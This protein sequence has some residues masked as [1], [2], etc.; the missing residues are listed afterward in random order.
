M[1]GGTQFGAAQNPL[2]SFPLYCQGPLHS[3]AGV[4]TS[5][6]FKWASVGAG[7]ANP[8]MGE[9]VWAD[10]GPRGSEIEAGDSNSICDYSGNVINLA[11][12]EFLEVGVYRDPD[13][14]NCMH[15]TRFVGIVKPPF[16]SE[17]ALQPFVRQSISALSPAQIAS[18][19][20]GIEVMMTRPV[21]DPTSYRF[22]ANIHGTEDSPTNP[23]E[24]QAWDQCEHGSFYFFSWHRMY[25]YFF[26]RILR[27]AAKDPN[28]VLPYWNWS[29]PAQRALPVAFRQPGDSSNPLFIAPPGRPA[30]VDSG[31]AMLA[32]GTVDFSAAFAL[33]N[34][35]PTSS[36]SS[37]L[38]SFGG[39]EA[40]PLQFNSDTGQLENQPHNVVHSALGGLMGDPDTAAQDPIFWLHH[41]NI[42]R[43]WK[44]WLDQG[45]GRQDPVADSAWMNQTF[46]FFDE[47]GHAV[48]LTG[49]Q[50][51]DTISQLDYRYDDDATMSGLMPE[52]RAEL[53]ASTASVHPAASRKIL[54]TSEA[55][56][57]A[58]RI[59]LSNG[60]V[61]VAVPLPEAAASPLS[62]IIERRSEN[63]VILQLDDI[64][65]E[66]PPEF[67][68][69]VYIDPAK[70]ETLDTS[71][72]NYVGALS[73][74]SLKPH[75][76]AGHAMPK[77]N[78][79]VE[80]DISKQVR[81]LS[82]KGAWNPKELSVTLVPRGLVTKEGEPLPLP[83]AVV[84]TLAKI[85]LAT[86]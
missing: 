31:T 27:A 9:C 79:V 61:T 22:Q 81:D 42:D 83:A 51:I 3:I 72:P 15:L 26:D 66:K 47:A 70:G 78:V 69:E 10:R 45:G 49:S 14:N 52:P 4:P 68:Y 43:L 54:A 2:P 46:E 30:A 86:D 40:P 74:F 58:K 48:H 8:G 33:T 80:Y 82:A 77:P 38:S 25:L 62:A 55:G 12:G 21:T 44:R 84:G 50:I 75:A 35:L 59:E 28:L 13:V 17:P 63:K 57:A 65:Y 73:L 24:T 41:A 1:V 32:A 67:Y 85:A 18:L 56:A 7:A 23:V 34:F 16:S 5:T 60:P 76:M 39:G 19:R 53:A 29:D 71:S 36:S 20:H 37:S 64:Q 11:A 6:K